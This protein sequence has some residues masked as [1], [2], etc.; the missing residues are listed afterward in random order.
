MIFRSNYN[1]DLHEIKQSLNVYENNKD[2]ESENEEEEL[3]NVQ[4]FI[5]NTKK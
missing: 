5:L 3:N 1:V 4:K 2:S